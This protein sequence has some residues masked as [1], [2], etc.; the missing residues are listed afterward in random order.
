[1]NFLFP[2]IPYT[3]I[4]HPDFLVEYNTTKL[5]G[6]NAYLFDDEDMK[7]YIPLIE[8]EVIYRGWMMKPEQYQILYD[9]VKKSGC[10]LINN[11][12][13]YTTCHH[14]PE[15]Y[16]YIK[17][18][19]PK[20]SL[21]FNGIK[22]LGPEF[23]IKDYVKSEKGTDLFKFSTDISHDEFIT[24]VNKFKIQRG[25]SFNVGIVLKEVVQLK[26]YG[27]Y[28]NEWRLFIYKGKIISCDYNINNDNFKTPTNLN[29]I[30]DLIK[31]IPSNF[32]TIDIAEKEDG[33][34]TILETG[35]GG[36]SGLAV[37]ANIMSFYNSFY[38]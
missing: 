15:V 11:T 33:S 31:D 9:T 12:I 30:K 22:N 23:I 2:T 25:N 13:E 20:Y 5:L 21:E 36:V 17:D 34:W 26:K 10:V 27:I 28:T 3:K 16:K 1:M 38:Q 35:D 8:G 37:N 18:F 19:T 29:F 6:Y 4:V 14:F 24:I 7:V 32:Y